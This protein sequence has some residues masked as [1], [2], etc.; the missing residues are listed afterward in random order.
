MVLVG[1]WLEEIGHEINRKTL[2]HA[3]GTQDKHHP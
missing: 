3:C 2:H 1:E